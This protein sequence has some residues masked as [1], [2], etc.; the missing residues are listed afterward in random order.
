MHVVLLDSRLRGD[1]VYRIVFNREF[2]AV[3]KY[4][5]TRNAIFDIKI[6]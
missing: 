6:E 3:Y 5:I 4:T 1:D 2:E